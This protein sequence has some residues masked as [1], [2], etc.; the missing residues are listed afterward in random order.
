MGRYLP[1][2]SRRVAA[3]EERTSLLV[4]KVGFQ[5]SQS[6][7]SIVPKREFL[8][9]GAVRKCSKYGSGVGTNQMILSKI[10]S[11]KMS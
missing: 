2:C 7:K 4:Q 8:Q 10:K 5:V 1:S 11:L 6:L 9:T 3:A